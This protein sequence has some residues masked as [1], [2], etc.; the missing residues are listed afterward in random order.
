[1]DTQHNDMSEEQPDRVEQCVRCDLELDVSV[2][3]PMPEWEYVKLTY[4]QERGA[5]PICEDCFEGVRDR[6]LWDR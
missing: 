3:K 4:N 2:S 5:L 1:M 6:D